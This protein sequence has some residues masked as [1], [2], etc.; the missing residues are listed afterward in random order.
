MIDERGSNLLPHGNTT[1]INL[2]DHLRLVFGALGLLSSHARSAEDALSRMLG[3]LALKLRPIPARRLGE[4]RD[5]LDIVGRFD[6]MLRP[7]LDPRQRQEVLRF[8]DLGGDALPEFR[9]P[10]LLGLEAGDVRRFAGSLE[11]GS[12]IRNLHGTTARTPLEHLDLALLSV[13]A[14]DRHFVEDQEFLCNVLAII[15]LPMR[16]LASALSGRPCLSRRQAEQ[17]VG[18][19]LDFLFGDPGTENRSNLL[20]QQRTTP[21]PPLVRM[22]RAA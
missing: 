3:I 21:R 2:R 11:V 4:V 12:T 10:D 6:R 20:A 19:G 7:S 13:R 8:L 22:T 1:L 17:P 18:G 14:V 15:G 16:P 5:L 9:E